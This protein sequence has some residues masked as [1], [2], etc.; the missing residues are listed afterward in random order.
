LVQQLSNQA[1]QLAETTIAINTAMGDTGSQHFLTTK[2]FEFEVQSEEAQ[3]N[4][5]MVESL[6]VDAGE[7]V[8]PIKVRQVHDGW[9]IAFI[10][11][12]LIGLTLGAVHLRSRDYRPKQTGSRLRMRLGPDRPRAP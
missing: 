8:R 11:G 5:A 6:P 2:Q 4:L 10:S 1:E 9:Y 12:V 7:I 3:S